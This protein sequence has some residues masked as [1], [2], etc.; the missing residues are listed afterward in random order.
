MLDT[1]LNGLIGLML[2]AMG[3]F[4][5]APNAAMK[6]FMIFET[7]GGAILDIILTA[8][9][10]TIVS[11]ALIGTT[12]F[13]IGK[14]IFGVKVSRMDGSKLGLGAGLA[15]DFHVLA[16]GLGLGIPVISLV[17]MVVA[18]NYLTTHESTAW[19]KGRYVV[20]HRPSG[21]VQ[22]GLNAIGI[23]VIVLLIYAMR[24]SGG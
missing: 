17:T 23:C 5:I 18:Y 22:Y 12:G 10:G 11:G 8:L 15:R 1:T 7:P 19:D 9:I 20:R 14:L 2:L 16:R 6:F 4:A 3:F 21:P 24:A 13:S